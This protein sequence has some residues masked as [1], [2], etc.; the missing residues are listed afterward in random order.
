MTE[1]YDEVF[2]ILS[3]IYLQMHLKNVLMDLNYRRSGTVWKHL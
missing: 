3:Q 2:R 1:K